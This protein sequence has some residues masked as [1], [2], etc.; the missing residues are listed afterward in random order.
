[1]NTRIEDASDNSM[2]EMLKKPYKGIVYIVMHSDDHY[3]DVVTAFE[4]LE[5][6]E[7]HCENI[8]SYYIVRTYVR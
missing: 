1:M 8:D 2:I 3:D 5:D 4:K 6:A 7:K